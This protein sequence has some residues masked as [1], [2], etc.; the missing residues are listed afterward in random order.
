MDK[1]QGQEWEENMEY[2]DKLKQALES[3]MEIGK[4][5]KQEGK[6]NNFLE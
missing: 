4:E 5:H 6:G 3:L 2:L 1:Y